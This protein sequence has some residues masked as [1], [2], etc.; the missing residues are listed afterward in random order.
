MLFF[1]ILLLLH[2]IRTQFTYFK[3]HN[4]GANEVCWDENR[5]L[6]YSERGTK[7]TKRSRLST[8]CRKERPRCL[9]ELGV[10]IEQ[11]MVILPA[12]FSR[13]NF[14][15]RSKVKICEDTKSMREKLMDQAEE[16]YCV[17]SEWAEPTSV[18]SRRQFTWNLWIL[19]QKS[20]N[21]AG[22]ELETQQLFVILSNLIHWFGSL[23]CL[24]CR[25]YPTSG[26]IIKQYNKYDVI[27]EI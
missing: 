10:K 27:F 7:S 18:L 11:F 13:R 21:C 5:G 4:T 19:S 23:Q 15:T 9:H 17:S 14:P 26:L 1:S 22:K 3:G 16:K 2:L 20:R 25:G 6:D 24:H 8:W 12:Q